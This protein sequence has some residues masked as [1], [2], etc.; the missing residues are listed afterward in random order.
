[1]SHEV[2]EVLK[3]AKSLERGQ[4]ADLAYQLLRV[5]DEDQAEVEQDHVDAAWSAEFRSRVD[6][7]E[8]GE[9]ELVDGRETLAMARAMLAARRG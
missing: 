3:T 7:I 8:S 1:M 6:A 4:I 2:A 9:V 5:L